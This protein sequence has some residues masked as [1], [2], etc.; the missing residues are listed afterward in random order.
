MSPTNK[1]SAR[2]TKVSPV[3]A[4]RRPAAPKAAR[5]KR[6]P[7][8][9]KAARTMRRS[10]TPKAARTK[11]RSATPKAASAKRRPAAP[12]AARAK[13]RPAAPKPARAKRRPVALSLV[14]RHRRPKP[15][16][17][18]AP[19]FPQRQGAS[20][21]QLALFELLRA[22]AAVLAAIAGLSPATA[23]AQLAPG[24]WS[25]RQIVLHLIARDQAR[26]REMEAALR[27]VPASWRYFDHAAMA[28]INDEAVARLGHLPWPEVVRLL[29]S[30]R[31]ELMEELESVPEEPAEVWSEAHPFGW[32]IRVLPAH[33]RHH[34]DIIKQWRAAQVPPDA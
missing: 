7:V 25:P 9:P 18:V 24:K 11:R 22:R 12:K 26:L 31:Q 33:D 5:T 17:P 14:P 3:R 32:M 15:R 30:T 13:R 21:R 20:D 1:S 19:A 27:G 34:A 29:H 6:R 16:V 8:T 4:K 10:A 23:E 28:G 2:R